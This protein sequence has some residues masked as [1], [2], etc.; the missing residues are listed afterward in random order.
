LRTVRFYLSGNHVH[1]H[2]IKAL[3]EGC[4]EDKK[5]VEGF[6]YDEADVGVVFG[7]HK[8]RVP[9]SFPRGAVYKRHRSDGAEMV[10]LETGYIHR[11]DGPN[12]YY[13][14]GFNGLNGRADFK[15]KSSPSDRFLQLGVEVQPWRK[16]GRHIIVC[17]QVPWD[18]SVDHI[19]FQAWVKD[20]MWRLKIHSGRPIVFRD[21]P[22]MDGHVRPLD[23]EMRGCW[24]VVTFNSN[25]AVEAIIKGIPAWAFDEG[26]MAWEV[27]N[28]DI[29]KIENPLMPD[30]TQ[31]LNN[32][33][34]TQWTPAEMRTGATWKHLFASADD[35]PH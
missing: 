16:D 13:A 11:G 25:T 35:S 15:N 4:P 5:L 3:Y 30:R 28:K 14:A 26:A 18:A 29:A 20:V 23:D 6:E 27:C 31:W 9:I 7:V 2:V 8:S 19:D 1:D 17:G 34:Y 33:A 22:C 21:H 24:A 12:N 32:L 10:V